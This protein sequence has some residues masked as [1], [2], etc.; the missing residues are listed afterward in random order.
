MTLIETLAAVR[1]GSALAEAMEKRAEILRLSEAAHDAVLLP[2]DPGG[3]SHGLRAAL[4]ARMARHNRNEALA[5]HYDDLVSRAGESA[6]ASLATPGANVEDGRIAEIVRHADRLTVAPREATR[7]HID[8]LRNV[9]VSD[10][11]IVRLS[12]LAAFVNYQVRV[13]AGL[14]LIGARQ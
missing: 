12:E 14:A 3:L 4:A 11:D 13:V 5:S 8:A 10:A 6:T 9:G 2:R 1:P 7:A